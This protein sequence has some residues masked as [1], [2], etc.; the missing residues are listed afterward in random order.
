MNASLDTKWEGKC[1]LITGVCGTVGRELLRQVVQKRPREVVGLDNRESE[2]FFVSEEFRTNDNVRVTLGDVRDRNV[3]LSAMDGIHIV[4]HAAALK[5]VILCERGPTEAVL[6]NITGTQNVI[7][8]AL[9]NDVERVVYTSS[10]KAV[11]P[12]SVMGTSKL[13]GERLMTAANALRRNSR[14]IFSSTRFGNVL[15]SRGS[16]IPLF[17]RQIASGGPVTLTSRDM[18]RFIMTLEEAVGLVLDSV[19]LARGGEVLVTKMPVVRIADLAEVMVQELAPK[20]GMEP[21]DIEI[22]D[23]GVRPGEKFYEEL[24]NEE[25]LRRTF[26]LDNYFVVTPAFRCVYRDLD[27]GKVGE[28][29]LGPDVKGLLSSKQAVPMS[30]EALTDYVRENRL[31]DPIDSGDREP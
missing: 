1:V 29:D 9:A 20:W 7:D 19:F 14:P 21:K 4:L 18:T 23:I 13:M 28:L 3:L 25:E 15:G 30:R 6:T 11:N 16:V 12:T 27:Y 10:D 17:R 24:L 8:A 22:A 5:H 26:E 31:L 2:L